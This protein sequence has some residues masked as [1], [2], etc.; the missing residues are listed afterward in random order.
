MAD[1]SVREGSSCTQIESIHIIPTESTETQ[2]VFD[3]TTR[4]GH[5][6]R[7]RC[8]VKPPLTVAIIDSIMAKLDTTLT[9]H[10]DLVE[11]VNAI[12]TVTDSYQRLNGLTAEMNILVSVVMLPS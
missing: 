4:D 2:R 12:A 1:R 11:E 9:P 8:D 10:N 6:F 5:T 7:R 3:L